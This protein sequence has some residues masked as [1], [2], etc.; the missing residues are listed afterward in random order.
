MTEGQFF[1]IGIEFGSDLYFKTQVETLH[2]T[3]LQSVNMLQRG[4]AQ[5]INK[6]V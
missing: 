5:K 3:V 2:L 4:Q 1:G 6:E